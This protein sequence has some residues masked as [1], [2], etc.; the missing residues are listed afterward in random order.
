MNRN[1]ITEG[2]SQNKDFIEEGIIGALR[3]RGVSINSALYCVTLFLRIELIISFEMNTGSKD[4]I[5]LI[6]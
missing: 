5:M 2:F 4:Y 3:Y 6:D 1:S